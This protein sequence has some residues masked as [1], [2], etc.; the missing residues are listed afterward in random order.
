MEHLATKIAIIGIAG[1]A[2]QWI[3]WRLRIPGIAMLLLAGF[4]LGP[5]T[6]YLDPAQS[7]GDLYRPMI[8][9]AVAV[10]LFEGGLTLNFSEIKETSGGVR[11]IVLIGGPLVWLLLWPSITSRVTRRKS[12]R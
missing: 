10:I 7:F 11:R 9:L 2:A 5:V 6:G 3:A 8:A 4:I 1:I 12:T